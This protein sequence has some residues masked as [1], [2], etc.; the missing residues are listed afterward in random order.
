MLFE[1]FGNK[2]LVELFIRFPICSV[3]QPASLL[4]SF[5]DAWHSF[6][7]TPEAQRARENST[8]NDTGEPRL[9]K[10]IFA[11]QKSHARAQWVADW[12]DKDWNNWYQL[13]PA[14]QSLWADHN[15]GTILR[16]IAE[17]KEQQQQRFPGAAE[18]LATRGHF[19]SETLIYDS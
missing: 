6:R 9:S 16:Q 13:S 18:I 4:K 17:L 7:N 11:L 15:N 1:L 14:D 2:A 3:E 12:V 5:A 10:Q 19:S 8:K